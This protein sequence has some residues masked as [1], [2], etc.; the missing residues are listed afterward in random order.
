MR[1]TILVIDSFGIGALP[2]AAAYGDDGS[3]TALHICE[4]VEGPKW[5]TL[6]K[7]GLGN[8]G[9]L[10]GFTLP[11]CEPVEAPLA[12]W[13]V[14]RERSPG[15]DTTT[16]HWEIAG[17]VLDRPF[18]TFPAEYPSFPPELVSEFEK[19]I[20]RKI[21]GNK[22]ASGTAI[23]EELGEEHLRTGKPICYTSSDSVFQIAA[24]EEIIPTD[25]L[26]RYCEIAR[27][28]CD[29]YQVG[30]VIARPFVGKTGEFTRTAGRRDFSIELTG[31]SILDHL[32]SHGANTVA[33]GKIGDIFN[34]KGIS[35]SYHDKGNTLCLNRTVELLGEKKSPAARP[36]DE[37]IFVNL[38][39][40][41]MIYG[42]RRD[43]KGYCDA[44]AEIDSRLSE[45]MELLD[46]GDILLVTADHGCDPTFR[47]T[48]HTREHVPLLVYR[49]GMQGARLGIR[50]GFSDVAQTIADLL[51]GAHIANGDSFRA[52]LGSQAQGGS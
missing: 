41:D 38:V 3:N 4:H 8:A 30:R 32:S 24:H 26:Y 42:H 20:G 21:I 45:M 10:L 51:T 47:G 15:K 34:E 52:L 36:A 18:H 49:K 25:E 43:P 11:G 6:K 35:A 1:V 16:G 28:L 9:L 22:A 27:R 12:S 2:D 29:S 33:V 19:A 5:P 44:V 14:M 17:I 40:T 39:D 37:L 23:I 31:P 48:D 46:P 7:L 50:E 13:G